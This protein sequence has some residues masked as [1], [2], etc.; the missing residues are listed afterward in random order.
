MANAGRK[1]LVLGSPR[2]KRAAAILTVV[3]LGVATPLVGTAGCSCSQPL[4][5]PRLTHLLYLLLLVPLVVQAAPPEVQ[6]RLSVLEPVEVSGYQGDEGQGLKLTFKALGPNPA[7]ALFTLEDARAVVAALEAEFQEVVEKP[8]PGVVMGLLAVMPQDARPSTLERRVREE[9]EAVLGAALVGLPGSLESA[10]WFQ[11]LKLSPRYMGEGVREAAVEMFSS[12]AVVLSVGMAMMLYMMAWAAPEPVFSK[13]FAG[14][15]TLGL[16][17]TYT[18]AELYNVGQACLKLYREAEGARTR[19]EL[20]AVAERFGKALGG[21]GLRV[22][23]TVAGAKLARGLP[24]VPR[25]GLW[26]RL[27]PPR[28][29]FAG[30]G[31]RGSFTVGAGTRAQVSVANGTVVLMGVTANTTAAAVSSAASSARTTG[32]CAESKQKDNHRHHL[33]TNKN[34]TSESNGGP[35][36][37]EFEELFAQAGMS[38]EDPANIV[39]LRDHKGPH[40]KEYHS[41]IFRR[42]RDALGGCKPQA[43][44]R[45]KL[46]R[47]LDAIAGEV[48]TPGSKLNKL[49]TRKP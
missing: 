37:P 45:A 48:C 25:G 35:W 30:R 41:E 18:A 42:L 22:L 16:L 5:H 26:S 20:E 2:D 12:R 8:D 23:L 19:E 28:F 46:V 3:A 32:A 6:A 38:L 17:M 29:A 39:Y 10:R 7:L 15:V 47:A 27:S 49:A 13:A 31:A 11:A 9:Y 1:H 44:C 43:E 24:E 36:T 4:M 21:V 34:D 33:C 14:A 40:P